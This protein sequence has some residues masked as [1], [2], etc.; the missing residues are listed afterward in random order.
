MT[1]LL[2]DGLP[3]LSI[4]ESDITVDRSLPLAKQK[5][6]IVPPKDAKENQLKEGAERRAEKQASL[7]T[8]LTRLQDEEVKRKK[9][10]KGS[11]NT[12]SDVQKQEFVNM[13][14][15]YKLPEYKA[16]IDYIKIERS[17]WKSGYS[18]GLTASTIESLYSDYKDTVSDL[19]KNYEDALEN[20]K[21]DDA[22]LID[23]RSKAKATDKTGD[24]NDLNDVGKDIDWNKIT[25]D[26]TLGETAKSLVSKEDPF[27]RSM[28]DDV[29]ESWGIILGYLGIIT[30]LVFGLR[31]ASF[32]VNEYFYIKTPYKVLIFVYIFLFTPIIFP[33]FIY[34]IILTWF[35]PVKYPHVIYRSFFPTYGY[36][37]DKSPLTFMDAWLGYSEDTSTL[38]YIQMMLQKDKDAKL[39]VLKSSTLLDDLKAELNKKG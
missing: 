8:D 31:F 14:S 35:N 15:N 18:S 34:K 5:N 9:Y 12:A 37:P 2:G 11:W 38:E 21:L 7:K 16:L 27:K 17:W 26:T 36:D 29:N 23:R 22:D 3:P 25:P 32:T 28:W 33:Y 1:S 39:Y 24:T 4:S 20:K 19:T 6:N 30:W 10:I 13:I